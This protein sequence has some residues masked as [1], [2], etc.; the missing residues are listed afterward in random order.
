[1]KR[2]GHIYEQI[3]TLENC[4]EAVK[5]A[6]KFKKKRNRPGTKV[7]EIAL[8]PFYYG[9]L[10]YCMLKDK[11]FVPSDPDYFIIQEGINRKRREIYA[12]K[13]FPDQII[14][15]AI[16]QVI[17]PMLHK[18]FYEYSCGSLPGR[19][20]SLVKK[21]LTKELSIDTKHHVPVRTKYKYCLKL[22]I[23][24]YFQSINL[25]IMSN[26]LKTK[27]K[28][29]DLLDLLNKIIYMPNTGSGLPIGFYTSQWLANLYLDKFDHWLKHRLSE[30]FPDNIYIRYVDDLVIVGSNKRKLLKLRDEISEYLSVNLGLKLKYDTNDQV[31]DIGKRPIDFVGFKFTYGHATV[32]NTIFR[33]ALESEKHL[34]RSEYNISN[35]ASVISYLGWLNST[36]TYKVKTKNFKFSDKFYRKKLSENMQEFQSTKKAVSTRKIIENKMKV[37]KIEDEYYDNGYIVKC[38][39]D[40]DGNC[41]IEEK[42]PIAA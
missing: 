22:D 6:V 14:H 28:D 34:N 13:L 41:I 23:H 33:R 5:N 40:K 9:Y 4:I 15:W 26:I 12:P 30:I 7:F 18:S 11:S 16:I 42:I 10:V 3:C 1:M 39:L 20:P 29:Q 25:D 38:S 32:R 17:G 37:Y 27:F 19:G 31:F 21:Y 2:I 36:D 24:H 8:N 35:L